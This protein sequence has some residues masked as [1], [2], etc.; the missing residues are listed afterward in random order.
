MAHGTDD[1][2]RRRDRH[3]TSFETREAYLLKCIASLNILQGRK[4]HG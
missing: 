3:V 1:P 4:S 2:G